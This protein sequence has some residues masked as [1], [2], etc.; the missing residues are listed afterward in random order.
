ML[1][2]A[3]RL[4]LLG[5]ALTGR[6]AWPHAGFSIQ[7]AELI[8]FG[9]HYVLN[10]DIDY[11]FSATAIDALENS[12]PLTLIMRCKIE[13]DRFYLWDETLMDYRRR[14]QIHY[15]P[16]GKLFQLTFEDRDDPQSYTSL[17]ALL[18]AL[19][20][21]R[22][23]PIVPAAWIKSGE[24]YEAGLSVSLDIESLPLPLRPTAYLSPSWYLGSS[25]YRWS[26]ERSE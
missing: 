14:M 24:T 6:T 9:G 21:I 1:H 3:L 17:D 18:G 15:H 5:L 2:R 11:G 26:F 10:A 7:R 12:V 19:G 23:L 25:W 13:R 16:L 20:T 4:C 8:R 22:A